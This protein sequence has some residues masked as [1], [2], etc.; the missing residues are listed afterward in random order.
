MA[1]AIWSDAT[2]TVEVPVLADDVSTPMRN[3]R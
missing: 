1:G 3:I 2:T